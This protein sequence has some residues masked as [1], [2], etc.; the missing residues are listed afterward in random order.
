MNLKI[1]QWPQAL[2]ELATQ[3][4]V[5]LE[6]DNPLKK[7]D[8]ISLRVSGYEDVMHLIGNIVKVAMLALEGGGETD[9]RD[10]SE[11][12]VNI[13]AVLG[14]ILDLIPYEEAE[15]LDVIRNNWLEQELSS[16]MPDV[17]YIEENI[18]LIPPASLFENDTNSTTE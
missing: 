2:Q 3:K 5:L 8:S 6:T 15:M 14:I 4:L 10:I 17:T 1:N 18:F 7:I 13:S 12:S 16:P 9:H 11:P